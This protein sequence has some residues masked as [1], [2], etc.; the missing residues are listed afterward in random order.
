MSTENKVKSIFSS[1][2][3]R[4]DRANQFLTFG[5]DGSWRK[6]VVHLSQV[7]QEDSVLDC[8]TGTGKLAFE[9]LS[10]LGERGRV[11]GVDFC[12]EMLGQIQKTDSRV[13]FQFADVL[14]LPF[15]DKEF[16]VVSIAYGLRNLSDKERG[17][18]EMARVSK[19]F[20]MILETGVPSNIFL[21]PLIRLH[22]SL[23]VPLI[24]GIVTKN[25]SAYRYLNSSSKNFPSGQKMISFLEETGC[26]KKVECFPL[27]GG[28]SFIYKAEVKIL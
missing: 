1:I 19:K 8:A 11:V 5:L 25:F 9:F 7:S 22:T 18:R 2:A 14:N 21:R 26:F 10:Q 27:L 3:K 17:V 15:S 4:Y 13:Q 23:L 20:V 6:K 24:G 16:N 28:A 12:K